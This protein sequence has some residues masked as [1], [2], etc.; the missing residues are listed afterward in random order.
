MA[1]KRRNIDVYSSLVGSKN[2]SLGSTLGTRKRVRESWNSQLSNNGQD[3]KPVKS[4]CFDIEDKRPSGTASIKQRIKIN[5]EL[6]QSLKPHTAGRQSMDVS[7][8]TKHFLHD[9][10]LMALSEKQRRSI[11]FKQ[12]IGQSYSMRIKNNLN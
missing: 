7:N 11:D 6:T 10:T 1:N 3:H 12:P 5:K 4:L 9:P 8:T 2:D